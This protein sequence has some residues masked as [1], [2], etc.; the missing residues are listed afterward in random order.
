MMKIMT[1]FNLTINVQIIP[2]RINGC[3][4]TSYRVVWRLLLR[5]STLSH[6]ISETNNS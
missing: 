2:Y 4:Y 5:Q 1:I 6:N 3:I